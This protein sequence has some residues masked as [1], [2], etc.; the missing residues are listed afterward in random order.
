MKSFKTK[1][2]I[3]KTKDNKIDTIVIGRSYTGFCYYY[4]CIRKLNSDIQIYFLT[5]IQK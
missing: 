5:C 2:F 1:S 3:L 4:M